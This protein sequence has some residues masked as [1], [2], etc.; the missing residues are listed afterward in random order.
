MGHPFAFIADANTLLPLASVRKQM[1]ALSF[2]TMLN[3]D[4]LRRENLSMS[5][6]LRFL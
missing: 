6:L 4:Y 5:E 2:G 1:Q 3:P